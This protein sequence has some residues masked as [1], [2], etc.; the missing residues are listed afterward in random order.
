[1]DHSTVSLHATCA[2]QSTAPQ[3]TRQHTAP[4]SRQCSQLQPKEPPYIQSPKPA[5]QPCGGHQVRC[6]EEHVVGA[7][8]PQELVPKRRLVAGDDGP[9]ALQPLQE[10]RQLAVPE[11]QREEALRRAEQL[12]QSGVRQR[13]RQRRTAG[14]QPRGGAAPKPEVDRHVLQLQRLHLMPPAVRHEQAIAGAEHRLQPSALR[15]G[16]VGPRAVVG[17]AQVHAGTAV[18]RVHCGEGRQRLS[19]QERRKQDEALPS[20][21]VQEDVL[22]Q[23]IVARGD[24]MGA[25][26]KELSTAG[27]T[28]AASL[29]QAVQFRP[30]DLRDI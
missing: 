22:H 18:A 9:R 20:V 15:P 7:L 5:C 19:P 14:C 16:H 17:A 1:M 11:R 6:T 3:R 27:P 26:A 30:L 8:Q 10:G 25:A 29:C 28:K 24:R 13:P 23:V 4:P 12:H 2:T 21:K